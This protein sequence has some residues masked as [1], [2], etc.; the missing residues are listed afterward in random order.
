MSAIIASDR[1]AGEMTIPRND[2]SKK[3]G[4]PE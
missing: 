1:D 2:N 3:K 4:P